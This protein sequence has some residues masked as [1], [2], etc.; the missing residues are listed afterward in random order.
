[1]SLIDFFKR[2]N[3]HTNQSQQ[4]LY[5]SSVKEEI[6]ALM[7]NCGASIND[8]YCLVDVT[9][10]D[11][12]DL[13]HRMSTQNLKSACDTQIVATV[14]PDQN[15][16]IID[17]VYYILGKEKDI[18][19]CHQACHQ[20]LLSWLDS[21]VFREDIQFVVR[22]NIKHQVVVSGPNAV[23]SLNRALGLSLNWHANVAIW[24]DWQGRPI[25][26]LMIED[27]G[28]QSLHLLLDESLILSVLVYLMQAQ[29]CLAGLYAVDYQRIM[30]L[31]PAANAEIKRLYNP[32]E[33]G[34]SHVIDW[35][36]GCYVGQEVIARLDTYQKIKQTLCRFKVKGVV[37]A[38]ERVLD[39]QGQDVGVVTSAVCWPTDMPEEGIALALI[40]KST[41]QDMPT[42]LKTSQAILIHDTPII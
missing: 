8:E 21:M 16:R 41:I 22:E 36:K 10:K 12:R 9:G 11:R 25:D 35:N 33:I 27:K 5:W 7:N 23:L 32:H 17:Y 4:V 2:M 26:I 14:C 15:G 39:E 30:H 20:E 42:F 28:L 19:M 38:D 37:Q 13:M 34:L 29:V 31:L 24:V 18:M 1:M 6:H 3:A 40:K